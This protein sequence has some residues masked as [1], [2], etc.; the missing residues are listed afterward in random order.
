MPRLVDYLEMISTNSVVWND[1]NFEGASL[2]TGASAPDLVS[3]LGSGSILA[4]AFDGNV[5][6]EQM[7]GGGEILHDYREG[8]DLHMHVHWMPTTTN[9]GNVEWHMEYSW[10]NVNDVMPAPS[11][12]SSVLATTGSAWKSYVQNIGIAS[13]T[14][15][16]IGSHVAFRLYRNPASTNDTYPDDAVLLSVGIHHE[17]D[18][19]GSRE[20][21]AK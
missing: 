15:K 1:I 8:T 9:T 2:G 20:I 18:S 3:I 13:G 7:Y 17:V 11:T 10:A 16:K 14:G 5:T 6:L 19:L 4:R 12:I 21:T